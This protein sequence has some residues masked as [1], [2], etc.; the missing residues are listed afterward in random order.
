MYYVLYIIIRL[1]ILYKNTST[2]NMEWAGGGDD[3]RNVFGTARA[4][5]AAGLRLQL[6]LIRWSSPLCC[7]CVY[8]LNV[9]NA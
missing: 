5:P 3:Q 6:P 9:F 7:E 1:N 2:T 4:E 8:F